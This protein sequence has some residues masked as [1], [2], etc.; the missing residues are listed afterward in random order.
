MSWHIDGFLRSTSSL[1]HST[2]TA[3]SERKSRQG[4]H[5]S[6]WNTK[7]LVELYYT[8]FGLW[9]SDIDYEG[10][11]C[12]IAHIFR[13][14]SSTITH[15]TAQSGTMFMVVSSSD[16]EHTRRHCYT[17]TA[18]LFLRQPDI[19]F[20]LVSLNLGTCREHLFVQV[21]AHPFVFIIIVCLK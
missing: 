1:K 15:L 11:H 5:L 9:I 18:P 20:V 3:A 21:F 12:G 17:S 19:Q 4:L 16:A 2:P 8:S 14:A 10:L 13:M 7:R 6:C